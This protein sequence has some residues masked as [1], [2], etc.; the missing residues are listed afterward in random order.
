MQ[1]VVLSQ[2]DIGRYGTAPRLSITL[3]HHQGLTVLR[4]CLQSIQDNP[5]AVP[6]EVIVVDNASS[7]GAP[8]M[9]RREFPQV[10]LLRN[11]RPQGFGTNQNRA[12]SVARGEYLLLLNDDTRVHP[13]ALDALCC[14][15]D[16]HPQ[17]AV[18]GPRLLHPDGTLQ[19]SCYRFPSPWR[20]VL[21]N[22]L[23]VAA[24]PGHPVIGDYRAWAHD[25]PREV[26]FVIGA[27]MLVRRCV[28]ER[29]GGFDE[30]FFL[31]FEEIDWQR[32]IRQQGW[33]VAFCPDAVITHLGGQSTRQ[34]R[35]RQLVEF[36]RSH[37]RFIRK[38]Y[39][40]GGALVL[41]AMMLIGSL[42]RL[43]LWTMIGLLHPA[44]RETAR[45][46]IALWCFHLRWWSGWDRTPGLAEQAH[47]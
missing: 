39:G 10:I 40:P 33:Q 1:P 32:R 13:R 38:H 43:P 7:E 44:R 2:R 30:A 45:A 4:D 23:L 15:M 24:F 22:L 28:L 17:I 21:E 18:A 36:N 9:V 27:A 8:E 19:I 31:Y 25:T 26:D 41:R 16:T 11:E 46:Q 20:S 47:G 35:P 6:F 3:V 37:L 42:L 34:V 29:V 5:P 12:M 14:Y